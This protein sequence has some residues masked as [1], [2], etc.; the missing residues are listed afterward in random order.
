M[1][2]ALVALYARMLPR[3]DAEECLRAVD[4]AAMGAGLM[5]KSDQTR[6]R[7][8]WRRLAGGGNS[9]TRKMSKEQHAVIL[10]SMGIGVQCRKA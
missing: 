3:L 7:A 2:F 9:A 5:E 10:A 8:E 1:P 4:I 6:I